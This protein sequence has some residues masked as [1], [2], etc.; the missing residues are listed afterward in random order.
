MSESVANQWL[1]L[2]ALALKRAPGLAD[3]GEIPGIERGATVRVDPDWVRDYRAILGAVDDGML[4]PCAPQV[5]A[6]G[7]HL[8]I[9]GDP[10]YPLPVLG[11][12]HLENLIE[13]RRPL[14]ATA[15]L[16]LRAAVSG[17]ERTA[18]GITVDIATEALVSGEVA[19]R[20][21]MKVLVRE[22]TPPANGGEKRPRTGD[23]ADGGGWSLSSTVR[24]PEDLGRR[25][26]RIAGD[27]NPIHWNRF[28]ARP[29]GFPRAIIH[30]MWTLARSLVEVDAVM[31]AR[32]RRIHA[33]FIRP[34]LLPGACVVSASRP[35]DGGSVD[36]VVAPLRPGAPHMK[37][38]VAPWT[39]AGG[40]LHGAAEAN[41]S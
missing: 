7:L 36:V 37:A 39:P 8:G 14:P 38:I 30:G 23:E 20:S 32:P 2:L 26:A 29:F 6:V 27:A 16:D 28:T 1:N 41:P 34:I 19:W 31:P 11:T 40:T 5:L 22:K 4:P 33:R 21:V 35:A 3:G 25:Y 15:T 17:H 10:R 18:R 9:L 12:I 24:L 13:E